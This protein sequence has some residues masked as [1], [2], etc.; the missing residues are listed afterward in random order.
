MIEVELVHRAASVSGGQHR[1]SVFVQITPHCQS[2]T[3]GE[4]QSPRRSLSALHGAA[5][6]VP[7][8]RILQGQGRP[9]GRFG[10]EARPAP[11]A[12]A[13]PLG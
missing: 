6:C 5:M 1:D 13:A 10:E 12:P 11:A 7:E 4:G 8:N 9:G 3:D 2:L